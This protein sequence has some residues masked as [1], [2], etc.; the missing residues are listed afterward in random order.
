MEW[1][2]GTNRDEDFVAPKLENIL[3]DP[4]RI[5]GDAGDCGMSWYEAVGVDACV[6]INSGRGD[7]GLRGLSGAMFSFPVLGLIAS[8]RASFLGIFR[9]GFRGLSQG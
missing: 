5:F 6:S 8:E 4:F 3:L 1:S 7:A 2:D 9:S